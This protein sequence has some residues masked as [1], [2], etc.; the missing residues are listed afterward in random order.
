MQTLARD[1]LAALTDGQRG[2]AAHAFT[3]PRR[4][5]WTYVPAPR[6]GVALLGLSG[7]A[8][9]LAHRLLATA[10][11]RHAFAQAVT[12]MALEEVLDLDEG[13]RRGRHSDGYQLAIFGEPGS[14]AWSWRFE[15]HHLSVT[16]TVAF[17]VTTVA[18][19]FLGAH[20]A[21]ISYG[22][23]AVIRPLPLEEELARTLLRELTPAQR[24]LA[25]V[26]RVAPP[27]ILSGTAPY[28]DS[29]LDPL[30]VSATD[31]PPGTRDLMC[32]LAEVYVD[33][34]APSLR[35][36]LERRGLSFA[37][38]GST[39]AG[40]G[41]YYRIQGPDLLI[42]YDNTQN[43]ADHAHTVLRRPGADFGAELLP[44]H[45]S[46]EGQAP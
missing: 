39:E 4:L 18:P 13:G 23:A 12:I 2:Q 40:E 25:I 14:E 8:R 32:R 35:L 28:V 3:D 27:D 17:G 37:W 43:G 31:L 26:D 9:K 42:E 36:P 6:P 20:P 21:A 15:G 45:L 30:G 24:D 33:R 10:L 34:L 46:P 5:R 16:A 7:Q 19:L 1:F 41:H 38:A 11:S 22:G 44:A 29:A